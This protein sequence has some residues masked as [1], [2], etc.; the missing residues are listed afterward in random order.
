MILKNHSQIKSLHYLGCLDE[1]S[2]NHEIYLKQYTSPGAMIAFEIEGD[3]K[4]AFRFLNRL[5]LIKLAV[6][7][8]STESLVQHPASMTHVGLCSE[9]KEKI[10][11][12]DSLVRLSVGVEHSEDLIADISNALLE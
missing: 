12:T 3:E 11:I 10:G 6:S 1:N 8:G 9:L 2:V 4:E 5:K 7:L